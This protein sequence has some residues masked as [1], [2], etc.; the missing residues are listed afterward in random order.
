M[1]IRRLRRI[2]KIITQKSTQFD[3]SMWFQNKD[4]YVAFEEATNG[5]NPQ[6][7]CG[8][9]ACIGGWACALYPQEARKL[10]AATF[11]ESTG[12]VA[13][14]LLELNDMQK[15]NLFFPENW[16]DKWRMKYASRKTNQGRANVAAKYIEHFIACQGDV[17][18]EGTS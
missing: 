7:H 1:N 8:T 16:P 6:T 12:E 9:V 14:K 13:S 17:Y 5:H 10:S 11:N 3:M 15:E 2:A 18:N 4:T